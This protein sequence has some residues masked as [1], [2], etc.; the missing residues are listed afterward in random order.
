MDD[1]IKDALG[2]TDTRVTF[3]EKFK[4]THSEEITP[5]GVAYVWNLKLSYPM[6]CPNCKKRMNYNGTKTVIHQAI[7]TGTKL[8]F[9]RIRKQ[10][11]LCKYCGNTEIA[12]LKDVNKREHIFKAVKQKAALD[13]AE[14]AS[15]KLI[16]KENNISANTVTRT[17]L[18][19]GAYLKPNYKF[20]PNH[21]AFDDFKS[22]KFSKSGMS[23][24]LVNIS[25]HRTIDV[26]ADRGGKSLEKNFLTYTRKAP[27][28]VM[29]VTVDLFSPYRPIIANVFPNAIILADHFH[30]VVQAY[31]ALQQVRIRIMKGFKKDSREHRQLSKFWKLIVKRNTDLNRSN[32]YRRRNFRGAM[33]TSEEIVQ[34]LLQLSP[35]LRSAYNFYQD[36]LFVIQ[37]QDA[38][39]L[40]QKIWPDKDDP[41]YEAFPKEMNRAKLTLR[42][43]YQEISN[44][45]IK[46]YKGYT[47][48]PVEGC[49]NKIKVIKRTAYGF[50]NFTNFRLR[51]L[52][53]FSTSFYSI[54]YKNSLKQLNKKTTNPP[55]RELVA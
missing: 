36:I 35:E 33:L 14:D 54:N 17:A 10:K 52:V 53:A 37:N 51:I 8:N 19:L 23:I 16:A 39:L 29:T 15:F 45:F 24:L 31:T 48:G 3:D 12:M 20:L 34:R 46:D 6:N 4:Q 11:Y 18:S 2:I 9:F 30:V 25:N 28:A 1:S 21:I 32:R 43:H 41:Q 38:Q 26:I 40:K 5:K 22:G 44:S 7:P 42:R 55:E 50:R 27:E 47:N 49:N 13:I